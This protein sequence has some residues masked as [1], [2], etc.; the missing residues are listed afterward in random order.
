[1]LRLLCGMAFIYSYNFLYSGLNPKVA[2]FVAKILEA[3]YI[4]GIV[5]W[6]AQNSVTFSVK[7]LYTNLYLLIPINL[8]ITI[9]FATKYKDYKLENELNN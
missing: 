7:H 5:F 9:I 1:M 2:N 3:N 6:F 8:L 4:I